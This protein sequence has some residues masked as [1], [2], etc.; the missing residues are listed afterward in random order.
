MNQV[1]TDRAY[2]SVIN[3]AVPRETK[4][5]PNQ[6]YE[7]TKQLF[8]TG[9]NFTFLIASTSQGIEWAIEFPTKDQQSLQNTLKTFYPDVEWVINPKRSTHVGFYTF[10]IQTAYPFCWSLS[11]VQDF[12]DR[13]PLAALVGAMQSV[14]GEEELIYE[15]SFNPPEQNY[16]LIAERLFNPSAGQ[17]ATK[18]VVGSLL[19]GKDE[20]GASRARQEDERKLE[21]IKEQALEKLVNSEGYFLETVFSIKV[22]AATPEQA[23]ELANLLVAPL[24][25]YDGERNLLAGASRESFPLVLSA[26]EIAALWHLPT[27]Q[28]R[29]I[30]GII[31]VEKGRAPEPAT[32]AEGLLLGM[33]KS[34]GQG[35]PVRLPYPDRV[36]HINIV[37][38]TRS[39]KSTLITNLVS[40]DINN[41]YA[42]A[43]IDPH[44]DLIKDI[45]PIIPPEREKDVI[46]LDVADTE[47]PIGLNLLTVPQNVRPDAVAT[48]ILSVIK[49]FYADQWGG[50][51]M[52]GA[53]YAAI[54]TLLYV[55]GSS[56]MKISPLF[57]NPDFRKQILASIKDPIVNEFWLDD[58]DKQSASG[59]RDIA[60]PIISRMREF[61]R[62]PT[63][64]RIICQS[65]SLNFRRV[66][67]RN[68]IFLA[69]LGGIGEIEAHTVGALLIAKFQLAGMSRANVPREQRTPVYL[70][71]DEVQNLASESL[72]KMFSEAG[73]YGLSLVTA[74]Q[75]LSQ[76]T[77]ETLGAVLGN[78]G[79]N[80][81]FSVG[82]DT[83][84]VMEQI[85][86]PEF[87]KEDLIALDRFNA[88]VRM[89]I[90]GKTLPAFRVTTPPPLAKPT[91]DNDPTNRIR[92]NSRKYGRPASEVDEECNRR[93]DEPQPPAPPP[94]PSL[95]PPTDQ[96]SPPAGGVDDREEFW[97]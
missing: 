27:E 36:T 17:V 67:D 18:L 13:D 70:Y 7:F 5:Q 33:S 46:L 73:K 50:P 20:A 56:V 93:Y 53:M 29:T 47:F 81:C 89:Q 54:L 43:V 6:V 83:A 52:Q 49:K 11:T 87:T 97:E 84:K 66:I 57:T 42:V 92:E 65:K 96:P 44:G 12:K 71:I 58:Y 77:D 51:R 64:R 55:P 80:I 16:P 8:A 59:Q 90:D 30:K 91:A 24:S 63:I 28:L 69:S 14:Q 61:Y 3:I 15:L 88:V 25:Q 60:G 39:G 38:K 31:W 95:P 40:Q 4:W 72:G 68:K 45:L 85:M 34:L 76:L 74:N 75:F 37:G 94:A 10:H 48:H 62:D 21:A 26:R 22:Q 1:T 19:Y 82:I 32:Q 2:M 35:Q 78:V 9:G 23:G 79:T 86:K 41:G